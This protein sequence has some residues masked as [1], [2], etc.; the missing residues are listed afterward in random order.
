MS[1]RNSGS[2]RGQD[3]EGSPL[4]R[5]GAPAWSSWR[6]AESEVRGPRW[7]PPCELRSERGPPRGETGR[8]LGRVSCASG[9]RGEGLRQGQGQGQGQA[10][11]RRAPPDERG[12]RPR[13]VQVRPE[14]SGRRADADGRE[15]PPCFRSVRGRSRGS[16][17]REQGP[18]AEI[19]AVE[20]IVRGLW[21]ASRFLAR[22]RDP[23]AA[24]ET[25]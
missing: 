14:P 12:Q 3:R 13:E 11:G 10:D 25:G 5:R 4:S 22:P 19:W 7:R 9:G 15:L 23:R 6:A 18:A 1:G 8:V 24:C 2:L 20:R 17:C 21:N 16:S